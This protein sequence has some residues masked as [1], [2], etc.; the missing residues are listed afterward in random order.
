MGLFFVLFFATA[1]EAFAQDGDD[2][3]AGRYEYAIIALEEPAL[4]GPSWVRIYYGNGKVEEFGK[5]SGSWSGRQGDI[6]DLDLTV[7]AINHLAEK[8]YELFRTLENDRTVEQ[9]IRQRYLF[10]RRK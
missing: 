9:S 5:E 3:E 7:S 10:R 8:G 1:F 2:S 6:R 4:A